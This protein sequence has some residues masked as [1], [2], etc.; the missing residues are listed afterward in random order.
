MTSTWR[1]GFAAAVVLCSQGAAAGAP[2]VKTQ[3]PG[4]YRMT[5]GD[6]EVTT[7]LDG[8]I[9]LEVNGLLTNTKAGQVDELLKKQHLK[10][11]VETSV[12]TFLI[13][14]GSKVVLIDAGAGSLFGPTVG[15]FLANLKA[16]GYT[17]EQIDAVCITHLHGDHMGGLITNGQRTFPNAVIHVDKAEA[18]FWLS[19]ANLDK[20]PADGKGGFQTARSVMKPYQD[21]GKFQPLDP[22]AQVVPGIRTVGA[23]GHTPGHSLYS[24]E[25]NGQKLVLWGDLLH[26][27]AVQ[28]PV[29]SVT[30]R[31]DTDSPAAR[32]QREK[33]LAEA[34]SQGHWVGIAHVSFPGIGHINSAGTGYEWIPANYTAN[35][36]QGKPI[37]Q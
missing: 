32:T 27:A 11:P 17:P 3:A 29:P 24:V 25:S 16:A 10:S 35:A 36:A 2:A 4:F 20:A 7:V 34:A 13:N 22:G 23:H 31:F 6:F 9:S 12:N 8:T 21:A 28:F 14:T 26:V 5:L 37:G 18:D 30:I 1:L 33:A 15:K 19:Q